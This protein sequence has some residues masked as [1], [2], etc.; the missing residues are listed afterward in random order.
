MYNRQFR[1]K[2]VSSIG[3]KVNILEDKAALILVL[4]IN[5]EIK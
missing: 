5:Y 2:L 1:R 3:G 4:P